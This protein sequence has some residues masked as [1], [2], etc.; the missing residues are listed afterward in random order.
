MRISKKVLISE[1]KVFATMFRNRETMAWAE[2]AS[3][4]IDIE[5]EN[6]TSVELWFRAIHPGA[7]TDAMYGISITEV[8]NTIQASYAYA[9]QL[10]KLNA[11][12]AEWIKRNGG[13]FC[14]NFSVDELAQLVYPCQ[15]FDHAHAFANVTRRLAYEVEGHINDKNP[16]DY[17]NLHLH[18]RILGKSSVISAWYPIL[19]RRSQEV[20]MAPE[21]V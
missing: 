16:T 15:E 1:S 5:D 6:I 10:E 7:M 21:Q 9:F 13:E 19:I 12:F 20:L 17:H 8:W 3:A 4:V 18:P 2:A 14:S 11:W